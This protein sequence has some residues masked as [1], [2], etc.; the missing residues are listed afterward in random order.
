MLSSHLLQCVTIM[1]QVHNIDTSFML[2]LEKKISK[3][4]ENGNC[5]HGQNIV[6]RVGFVG[7]SKTRPSLE[8][9]F[10]LSL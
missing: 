3:M 2:P 7:K 4:E 5:E 8:P 9:H 6:E 10:K 1:G